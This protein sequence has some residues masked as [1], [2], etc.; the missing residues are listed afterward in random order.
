MRY[1]VGIDNGVSGT[2][3]VISAKMQ[4][5][6]I[7]VPT[8]KEQNYTKKKQNITRID[9]GKL[10]DWFCGSFDEDRDKVFIALERPFTN[11]KYVN[12]MLISARALEATLNVL[13]ML[14]LQ[15]YE[16]VDSSWWQKVLLP[17]GVKGSDQLKKA[18][19][20]IGLRL[21][22]QHAALIKKHK[23]ADGLLIAERLR[24]QYETGD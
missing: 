22:P 9:V 4:S 11:I 2:I 20:D 23:D 5:Q 8:F 6:F 24:R 21:F 13:A 7:K 15:R 3:G 18:S 12:T 10:Y 19:L 17:K 14:S 16:Y 1:Y